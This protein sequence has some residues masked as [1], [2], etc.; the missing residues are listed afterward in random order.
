MKLKI[1][2]AGDPVLR[3]ASRPLTVEEI[4]SASVQQLIELMRETMRDAPGVGLAAPQ[5]GVGIQLAVIEDR[6]E[7]QDPASADQLSERHRSPVDFHVIINP[8]IKISGDSSVEFFEGCLSVAGFA[9]LVRRGLRVTVNC[10][11]ERAEPVT[12]EAEGWYAR[13]LQHEID[14]LKGTLY[15]DRMESRSFTT[16]ENMSR[17]WNGL[18]IEQVRTFLNLS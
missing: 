12:I 1:V 15:I 18:T 13:I 3:V 4:K 11:N 16:V 17:V 9:G 8:T 5:I 7:Y 10:L 6:E 14:H 2:Q